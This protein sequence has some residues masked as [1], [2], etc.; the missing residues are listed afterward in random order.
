MAISMELLESSMN[1]LTGCHYQLR[2]RTGGE[3]G[4]K[5]RTDLIGHLVAIVI[6]TVVGLIFAEVIQNS[7]LPGLFKIMFN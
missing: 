5:R 3:V 6:G 1:L 7:D 4:M 2:Q